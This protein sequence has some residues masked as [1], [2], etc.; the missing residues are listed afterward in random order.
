MQKF[1]INELFIFLSF[2]SLSSGRSGWDGTFSGSKLTI[3]PDFDDFVGMKVVVV[4]PLEDL[5]LAMSGKEVP[6]VCF[7][8]LLK[9]S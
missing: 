9:L 2:T 8:T 4:N 7:V 1:P 6:G 5:G 3:H